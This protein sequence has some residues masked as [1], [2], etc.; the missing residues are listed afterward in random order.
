MKHCAKLRLGLLSATILTGAAF[1]VPAYAE[2]AAATDATDA[3][4]SYDGDAIIV[5]G[6][7]RATTILATPI[8]IA[9]VSSEELEKQLGEQLTPELHLAW[10]EIYGILARTMIDATRPPPL[11]AA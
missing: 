11:A 6:T 2:E 10:M 1:A 9:A 5:T 8:N 7:R 4:A 3:A